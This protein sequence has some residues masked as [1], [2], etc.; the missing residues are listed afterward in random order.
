MGAWWGDLPS[1]VVKGEWPWGVVGGSR[2]FSP[3][4]QLLPPVRLGE[5]NGIAAAAQWKREEPD[6]STRAESQVTEGGCVLSGEREKGGTH[7][8]VLAPPVSLASSLGSNPSLHNP[9]SGGGGTC[10]P[11]LHP[12]PSPPRPLPPLQII[13]DADSNHHDYLVHPVGRPYTGGSKSSSKSS[14]T[15][16]SVD[17]SNSVSED[18]PLGLFAVAMKTGIWSPTGSSPGSG[19]AQV[20]HALRSSPLPQQHGGRGR[21]F[22]ST[23]QEGSGKETIAPLAPTGSRTYS[24]PELLPTRPPSTVVEDNNRGWPG[25]ASVPG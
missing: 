11:P 8:L 15:S 22:L 16:Y 12:F 4:P 5:R 9:G 2:V 21:A 25:C 17:S 19:K 14:S 13:N 10:A 18:S 3:S 6:R 23:L 20:S 7:M 1:Q 24:L